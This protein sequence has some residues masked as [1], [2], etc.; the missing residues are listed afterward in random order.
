MQDHA[1]YRIMQKKSPNL[2]SFLCFC[3][4]LLAPKG[5]LEAANRVLNYSSNL[6][7]FSLAFKRAVA[8][9]LACYFFHF[10]LS[11]RNRAFNAVFV[12]ALGSVPSRN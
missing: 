4:E 9:H 1:G 2:G 11:L 5:V 6:I 12:H 3:K 10:T 8:R 7:G